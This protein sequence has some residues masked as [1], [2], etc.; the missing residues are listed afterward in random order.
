MDAFTTVKSALSGREFLVR[1]LGPPPRRG[2]AWLCPFH[3]DKTPSLSGNPR[4]GGIICFGCG[5]RGDIFRFLQ[6]WSGCTVAEALQTAADLAQIIL[7]DP[8][9]NSAKNSSALLSHRLQID[10]QKLQAEVLQEIERSAAL[11]WRVAFEIAREGAS[12]DAWDAVEVGALADRTAAI[13]RG[14]D[15]GT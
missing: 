1:V 9:E 6:D 2:W 11:A 4:G 10:N 5:W 8:P 13:L 7:P 3:D 12:D 15:N 14:G